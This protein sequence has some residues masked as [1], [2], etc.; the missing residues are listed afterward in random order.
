MRLERFARVGLLSYAKPGADPATKLILRKKKKTVLQSKLRTAFA[1]L[2]SD[3][4]NARGLGERG[5][6]CFSRQRPLIRA[7]PDFVR[8]ISAWL[9]LFSRRPYSLR[10]RQPGTG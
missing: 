3:K 8:L 4:K 5:R 9:V 1:A 6:S 10:A 2:K 7:Y